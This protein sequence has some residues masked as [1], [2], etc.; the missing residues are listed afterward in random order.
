MSE[1]TITGRLPRASP[2]IN[3]GMGAK[4][5][6]NAMPKLGANVTERKRKALRAP[7][8]MVCIKGEPLMVTRFTRRRMASKPSNV[9]A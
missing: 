7:P 9:L 2:T 8:M 4:E 5:D 6:S 3:S 1:A